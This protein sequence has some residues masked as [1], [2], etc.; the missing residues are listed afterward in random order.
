MAIVALARRQ[1]EGDPLAAAH[2]QRGQHVH[3]RQ[4][5][6]HWPQCTR[7]PVAPLATANRQSWAAAPRARVVGTTAGVAVGAT[8]VQLNLIAA[9]FLKLP[10]E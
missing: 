6:T 3:D 9:R 10:R 4:R 8:E 1:V 7:S 5:G 2:S